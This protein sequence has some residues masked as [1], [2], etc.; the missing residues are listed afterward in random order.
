[1]TE[2][3][4][5]W[6]KE[7]IPIAKM[8]AS[9]NWETVGAAFHND[10][11]DVLIEEDNALGQYNHPRQEGL[12]TT[13]VTCYNNTQKSWYVLILTSIEALETLKR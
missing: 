4:E 13:D 2:D 9:T 5:T 1:M 8:T 6:S 3:P 11:R 7:V 12:D 10:I